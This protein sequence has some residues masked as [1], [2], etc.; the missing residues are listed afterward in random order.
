MRIFLFVLLAVTNPVPLPRPINFM[1]GKYV[2][3]WYY[4]NPAVNHNALFSSDGSYLGIPVSIYDFQESGT[5]H[6]NS[7]NNTLKIII[8]KMGIFN[9]YYEIKFMV[10]L[11]TKILKDTT[12]YYSLRL[13]KS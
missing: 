10:T 9:T 6:W 5:W 4:Q 2:L 12:G 3:S 13:R 8:T 11:K 7:R 1:P